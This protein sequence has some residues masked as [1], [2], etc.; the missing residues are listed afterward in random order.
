MKPFELAEKLNIASNTLSIYFYNNN[1]TLIR[2]SN[3]LPNETNFQENNQE[4]E[5]IFLI[6]TDTNL[7]EREIENYIEKNMNNYDVNYFIFD[8][9]D[10][11]EYLKSKIQNA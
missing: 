1:N 3:H 6:F 10:N 9:G 7:T 5:R 4:N 8:D 2:I 11:F